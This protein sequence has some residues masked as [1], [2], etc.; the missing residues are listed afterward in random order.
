MQLLKLNRVENQ[1][2]AANLMV[3]LVLR[4]NEVFHLPAVS[5]G[6]EVILGTAW[7]TVKGRDIFLACGE[8]FLLPTRRDPALISAVGRTPLI[9]E[10]F[11]AAS[12]KN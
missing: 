2:K 8:K 10:I 12:P 5:Q 11:G 3:R 9:L 6:I 1:L 7:V 4:R